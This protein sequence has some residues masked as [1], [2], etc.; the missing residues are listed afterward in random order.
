MGAK[1]L[2]DHKLGAGVLGAEKL[3]A[4]VSPVVGQGTP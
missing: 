2:G 1:K 4:D 3:A